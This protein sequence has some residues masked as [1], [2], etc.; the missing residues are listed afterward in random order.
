VLWAGA[1]L[2]GAA[3]ILRACVREAG[4]GRVAGPL[5]REALSFGGRAWIGSLA[6]FLTFRADQMLMGLIASEATLGLY[7]VAVNS[8][9]V[10][11]YLPAAVA[12]SLVP[13]AAGVT[14]RR[15]TA[16]VLDAF[17]AVSLLT[18]AGVLLLAL[19]GPPL[20]PVLFGAEYERSVTPFLLLL[21]GALG[22]AA[23]TVFSS[24][25]VARSSPGRSSIG[26]IVAMVVG[27]GLDALLIPTHGASGAAVAASASFL[28]GGAAAIVAYHRVAPFPLIGLAP[29]PGDLAAIRRA[30]R[31]GRG[32]VASSLR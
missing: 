19:V 24:A 6:A 1:Q 26:S 13:V 31:R 30:L 20:V 16:L 4:L 14:D 11:L 27:L 12:A 28:A 8:S 29:A 18:L 3:L 21:P 32:G 2:A 25:L 10:L 5:L 23:L 9:E 15:R 22:F 17:R 7:V